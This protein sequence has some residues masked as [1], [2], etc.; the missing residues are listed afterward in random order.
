MLL[1]GLVRTKLV[2]ILLGPPGVGLVGLYESATGLVGTIAGLGIAQSGV[3]QVAEAHASNDQTRIGD[4]VRVLRR[5]CWWTGLLGVLL[6]AC[7]ARLLSQWTFGN[8]EQTTAIALLG[9]TILFANVSAGQTALLQGARRIADLACLNIASA[10]GGC[11]VSLALYAWLGA[12]GIVPALIALAAQ[13][14]YLSWWFARRVPVPAS[15]LSWPDAA[16]QARRFIGLGITF[17]WSGLL[18]AAV[19]WATRALV[20]RQFGLDAN[21]IYQ[22]AWGISG[23]FAGFILQAM[24]KDFYPRLAAVANDRPTMNRLVNEQTEIGILMALPGL[25]ATLVFS[26]LVIALCYTGEFAEATALLPWFVLGVL[27]R[28]L[29]WP[30]GFVQVAKGASGWF[31][32]TETAAS[33]YQLLLTW[34]AM[35]WCGLRGAAIAFAVLYGTYLLGMRW[36]AGRL[37]GFEWTASVL[38]LMRVALVVVLSTFTLLQFAPGLPAMIGG[39]LLVTAVTLWTCQQLSARLGPDHAVSRFH[40]RFLRL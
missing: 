39:G 37:S 6:T 18:T 32:A 10:I 22:A 2:A 36:V 35:K 23:L 38:R 15:Q 9:I 5:T 26:P 30:V 19:A 28:V 11:V 4:T 24:G 20:V 21:G 33:G 34:A 25:L 17:M 16:K 1:I 29:S 40:A 14:M 13:N 3:R 27:G 31:A 7:I 8:N 12:R